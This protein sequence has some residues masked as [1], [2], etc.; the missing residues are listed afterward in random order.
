MIYVL[1]GASVAYALLH[2]YAAIAGAKSVKGKDITVMMVCGGAILIAAAV[3]LLLHL[4]FDWIFA[5]AG[6]ALICVAAF[7]NGKRGENFHLIHH[8]TRFIAST[9]LVIWFLML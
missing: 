6:F 5:A 2:I 8:I 9:G 7:L 1:F 4:S 3:M